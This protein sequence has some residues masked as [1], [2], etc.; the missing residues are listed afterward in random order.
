MADISPIEYVDGQRQ[1]S[2]LHH[3]TGDYLLHDNG[4]MWYAEPL[5][6]NCFMQPMKVCLILNQ[7]CN[8]LAPT[9]SM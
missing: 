6:H 2:L 5:S 4:G 9:R 3:Y 1:V 8:K 7:C